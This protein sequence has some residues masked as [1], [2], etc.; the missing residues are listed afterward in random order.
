VLRRLAELDLL[1]HVSV[2]STVSGGSI[3]GASYVLHLKH[4]FES[5]WGA[6]TRRD[7]EETVDATEVALRRGVRRNLR[8]RLLMTP[9]WN[10][11]MLCTDFAWGRRMARLYQRHLFRDAA[12]RIAPAWASGA[13]L[14]DLKFRPPGRSVGFDV[15]VHNREAAGRAEPTLVP[16]W[17]INATSLN[18]G[19]DFRF[20]MSEIGDPE[21]GS[22][23]FD[24]VA[25]ILAYK[26]LLE[27]ARRRAPAGAEWFPDMVTEARNRF[28]SEDEPW[29]RRREAAARRPPPAQPPSETYPFRA[30]TAAHLYW[31]VAARAGAP[32]KGVSGR[33]ALPGTVFALEEQGPALLRTLAGAEIGVLREAK[34]AA[35]Y[36]RDGLRRDPPATGG[37]SREQHVDRL[38][39]ALRRIQDGLGALRSRF[40]SAAQ[41]DF[42]E[43]LLD[44]YYFRSAEQFGWA[45]A[46][47]LEHLTLAD[48]V[49]A[50]A[51]FPPV[52]NP[53][54]VHG[55][56]A[57]ATAH[58]LA[59][60]DGGVYD[61]L[62][63]SA[64]LEEE[65]THVIVSDAGGTLTL[66]RRPSNGRIAMMARIGEVLM[67]DVRDRQLGELRER[68]RP[69]STLAAAAF[70][71][72]AS[73]PSAATPAG[74][75]PKPP[76]PHPEAGAIARLRTDLDA[77]SPIE[78]DALVY[79]GYQLADRFV[80]SYIGAPFLGAPQG[81]PPPRVITAPETASAPEIAQVLRVGHRRLFRT[82][83]L[84]PPLRWMLGGA[85]AALLV[86]LALQDLSI[87]ELA[88][89]FVVGLGYLL[90][91][92]F[93]DPR[94]EIEWSKPKG[95]FALVM[96]ILVGGVVW[97]RWPTIEAG[98]ARVLGRRQRG[99]LK[100]HVEAHRVA[101]LVGQ[102]RWN[103]WWPVGLAPLWAALGV[104]AAATVSFLLDLIPIRR[105]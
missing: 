96:V 74:G 98:L 84:L 8:T 40:S 83:A 35:W 7:Y 61:N 43:L 20:T 25:T 29:M 59:L 71:E 80:R 105:K 103:L 91:H 24:E 87:D 46:R 34:L 102:W 48:A 19:R 13:P 56:Y 6:L 81:A 89:R 41:E 90:T 95:V 92:P 94:W 69:G 101:R 50:S 14:Q 17:V 82:V 16:K 42:A 53:F 22:V 36:L 54:T 4:R 33:G 79:Q 15:E 23:R 12:R 58:R 18:T 10:L 77:F 85:G 3:L 68:R 5:S 88:R 63:V 30:F 65:C 72:M 57:P 1:R 99:S 49:A 9:W 38:W 73:D 93:L 64:L 62:G 76:D 31:W 2:L 39:M 32:W 47:E 75:G 104:A 45:A 70:F 100:A 44:V 67:A 78:V 86:L 52:F 27:T 51:N 37:Y 21:L 97:F 60:T 26:R 11:R 66:D 28:S 55:L